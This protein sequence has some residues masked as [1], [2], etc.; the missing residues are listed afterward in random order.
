MNIPRNFQWEIPWSPNEHSPRSLN[1]VH[2]VLGDEGVFLYSWH[3]KYPFYYPENKIFLKNEIRPVGNCV[4][5]SQ[6]EWITSV[7]EFSN[8]ESWLLL[9]FLWCLHK[10]LKSDSHLPEKLV[11][12]LCYLLDE[13]PLKIMNNAF[14]FSLKAL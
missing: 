10:R 11:W 9:I 5:D 13:N 1:F 4:K 7:H 2:F 14:Y 6:M 8:I 3:R 12:N